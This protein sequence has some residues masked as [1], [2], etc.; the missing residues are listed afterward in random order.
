MR[1]EADD[2]V[3]RALVAKLALGAAHAGALV[4]ADDD[5]V[6][7]IGIEGDAC[8]VAGQ[9]GESLQTSGG[10]CISLLK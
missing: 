3:S 4:R 7:A 9:Y 5:A 10:R 6:A 2:D 8:L 1:R